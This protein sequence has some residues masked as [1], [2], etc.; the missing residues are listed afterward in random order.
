VASP[1]SQKWE[2][3]IRPCLS[4][5]CWGSLIDRMP[6]DFKISL[7]LVLDAVGVTMEELAA[8]LG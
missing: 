2:E 6:R 7:E 1:E 8:R 5:G 3:K 4:R